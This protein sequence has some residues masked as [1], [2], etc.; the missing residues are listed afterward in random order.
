MA[1]LALLTLPFSTIF[2]DFLVA[3]GRR[4]S[5]ICNVIPFD[6]RDGGSS[7]KEATIAF[8]FTDGKVS[9]LSH[10]DH[11]IPV[12][13][14][15]TTAGYSSRSVR[16]RLEGFICSSG[17]IPSPQIERLLYIRIL[18]DLC[19]TDRT[20]VS[21]TEIAHFGTFDGNDSVVMIRLECFGV[22]APQGESC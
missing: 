17:I 3:V 16:V 9:D 19:G 7:G 5:W 14:L 1:L 13:S 2:D 8:L 10:I 6:V 12:E 4:T 11:L 21:T 20:K 18:V 22:L 15:P